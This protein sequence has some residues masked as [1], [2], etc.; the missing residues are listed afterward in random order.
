MGWLCFYLQ[1]NK[2]AHPSSYPPTDAA[3]AQPKSFAY[4]CPLQ[5]VPATM[6][7]SRATPSQPIAPPIHPTPFPSS[8]RNNHAAMSARP[9]SLTTTTAHPTAVRRRATP[10]R[11]TPPVPPLSQNRRTPRF[12]PD[13]PR[14]IPSPPPAQSDSATCPAH[15]P[16][17]DERVPVS[18]RPARPR[19]FRAT[20]AISSSAGTTCPPVRSVASRQTARPG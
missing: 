12:E 6:A 11:A 1:P 15:A 14:P 2:T 5:F 4:L 8:S 3:L 20:S 18:G 17:L 13:T 16:R 10:R 7:P 9:P 19:R